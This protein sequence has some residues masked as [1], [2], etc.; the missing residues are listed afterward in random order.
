M[1]KKC[2]SGLISIVIPIYN[3]ANVILRSISSLKRQTY[4]FNNMEII[5]VNDGSQD[6]SDKVCTRLVGRYNNIHYYCNAHKGVSAARNTGIN[7]ANGKYIFF[8]DAD[9]R[10]SKNTVKD[11]VTLFDSIYDQVDLLTYPIETYY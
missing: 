8:L 11:C 9:D 3:Q 2:M 6:S 10:I 5:L 4:G 7:A 1:E